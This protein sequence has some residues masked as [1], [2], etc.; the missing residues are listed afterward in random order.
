MGWIE[1]VK[2]II[3]GLK[4]SGKSEKEIEQIVQQAADKATVGGEAKDRY[5]FETTIRIDNVVREM[6]KCGI[7]VRDALDAFAYAV[8][9][10][11]R[12][13]TRKESNNWKKMHGL[14][15]RRKRRV[16]R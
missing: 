12:Y 8:A 13:E 3:C 2:G 6:R 7:K 1:K 5:Y 16:R 14:P 4:A 9:V 15:M 11:G 10:Q